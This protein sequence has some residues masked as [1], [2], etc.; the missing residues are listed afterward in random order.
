M[1][2]QIAMSDNKNLA[3]RKIIPFSNIPEESV[4][5]ANF[6]S[7][8]TQKT[9]KNAVGAFLQFSGIEHLDGLREIKSAHVIAW[10]DSLIKSGTSNR[11]VNNRM[12][13]LSSLFNHLCEKQ[14]VVTNPV[15]G[16]KRPKVDQTTVKTPALS[17]KQVRLMLDTPNQSKKG[18]LRDWALLNV[19][20]YTGCR[21]GAVSKLKVG[22]FYERSGYFVLDIREKGD[23]E[24]VVAIHPNLQAA[25]R[26]YLGAASHGSDK[27]APMFIGV[28]NSH[29]RK[30]VSTVSIRYI[31]KKYLKKI[32]ADYE[33]YSVHSARATFATEALRNGCPVEN[34]QKTLTHANVSTTLMYDTRKHEP[35]DSASFKVWY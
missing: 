33:R 27:N 22:D 7:S 19:L 21:E 17:V 5:L 9:Y 24:N 28:K 34:V 8:D 23:K 11:S 20:F 3:E 18:G 31:F 35:K 1:M 15:K 26:Q 12:S 25:L 13:A 4:W 10:R 29:L 16:L 6:I 30:T 32:I 14:L 2:N